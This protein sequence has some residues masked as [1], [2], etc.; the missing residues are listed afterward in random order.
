[1]Q[2]EERTITVRGRTV[3][4]FHGGRGQP[5]VFLHGP[6]GQRGWQPFLAQLADRYTIYAPSHPGVAGSTGLDEIDSMQDLVFHYFDVFDVWG[7]DRLALIGL[8]L[9]GWLAAEIAVACSHLLSHLVLVDAAGLWL[10]DHP[11]AD[12]FMMGPRRLRSVAFHDPEGPIAREYIPDRPATQEQL[13]ESIKAQAVVAKLAWSP[14]LHNP[15]LADRL[16]R[17]K[18]PTL[19]VWG[20]SDKLIPPP[21]AEAYQK[22][23]PGAQLALIEN[24]GHLPTVEQPDR[25]TALVGDFLGV[26]DG[27]SARGS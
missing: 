11:M 13:A 27:R 8:S 18:A 23:I 9:G 26:D 4:Y 1:M 19:I 24:A 2:G 7:L 17:V 21:Y 15:K 5:V 22:G 6:G 20:A 3:H 10:E 25:F 16:H 14:Y 12:L